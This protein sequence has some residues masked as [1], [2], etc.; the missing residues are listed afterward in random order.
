M[1]AEGKECSNFLWLANTAATLEDCGTLVISDSRCDGGLG[2]LT[3]DSIPNCRCCTASDAIT[4][5]A[6]NVS[7]N[8]YRV[9]NYSTRFIGNALTLDESTPSVPKIVVNRSMLVNWGPELIF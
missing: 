3:Y 6:S 9:P 4:N 8:I 1:V 2:Y 5:T 7:I